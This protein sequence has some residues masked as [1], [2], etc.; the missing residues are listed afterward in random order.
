MCIRWLSAIYR[1]AQ[2]A[3]HGGYEPITSCRRWQSALQSGGYQYLV[4]TP[5]PTAAIPLAWS[6]RDPRLTAVLHP[7]AGRLGLPDRPG[8][9]GVLTGGGQ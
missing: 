1:W 5:A 8:A 4:L 3:A 7:A 6:Q 2:P 9:P